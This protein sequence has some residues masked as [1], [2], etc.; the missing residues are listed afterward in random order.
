MRPALGDVEAD[1]PA[2]LGQESALAGEELGAA[3][4]AEPG[5]HPRRLEGLQPAQGRDPFRRVAAGQRGTRAVHDQ[6]AGEEHRLARQVDGRAGRGRD[7]VE[8]QEVDGDRG[9]ADRGAVREGVQ[10][11]G[12]D[13]APGPRAAGRGSRVRSKRG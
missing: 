2:E 8:R 11:R 5:D 3:P 10:D 9:I 6:R 4:R 1:L 13:G 12:I 7:L